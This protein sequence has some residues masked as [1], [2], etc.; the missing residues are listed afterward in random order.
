MTHKVLGELYDVLRRERSALLTG[1]YA[2]LGDIA[3]EKQSLMDGL[4]AAALSRDSL[5]E[6]RMTMDA[7]QALTGAALKGAKAAEARLAALLQVENALTTYDRDGVVAVRRSE[8]STV[9]KKA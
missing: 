9:E 6:L 2:V 1:Q 7:N 4:E 5:V 3:A 8:D